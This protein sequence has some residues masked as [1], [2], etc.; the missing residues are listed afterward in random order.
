MAGNAKKRSSRWGWGV[1]W[2]LIAALIL[3]NYFGGFVE[4]GIWSIIV[5]ALALSIIVQ[6]IATLSLAMIPIP[7]A[8]LYYIFQSPLGFPFIGFWTLAL[9]T[10]LTTCGFHILLPRRYWNS[11]RF[12]VSWHDDKRRRRRN[13]GD[14]GD[15]TD[16]KIE[17]GD[18]CN[19]PYIRMQFGHISRYLHSDCLESAELYCSC[20][21]MEVYFDHVKLSPDGAEVFVSCSIGSVEIYVPGSWRVID[22]LSTSLGNS[23]VDGRLETAD[24]NS[25]TMTLTGKV[26]LGNVEVHR[27]RG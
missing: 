3:S 23:E 1:F 17:E 12:E 11:K 8:A 19:N 18:D 9:V 26:S 14:G 25:P 10:V 21:A 5:T 7:L 15:C 27:I 20:G 24:E 22:N 16:A 6:N 13:T 4:L 2:L